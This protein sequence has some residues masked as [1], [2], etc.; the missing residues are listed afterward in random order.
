MEKVYCNL[1]FGFIRRSFGPEVADGFVVAEEAQAPFEQELAKNWVEWRT[2]INVMAL[3]AMAA[4]WPYR[5][6]Y[7]LLPENPSENPFGD[8]DAIH[9]PPLAQHS[10]HPSIV[11]FMELQRC[12]QTGKRKM[13][14]SLK[15]WA[16]VNGIVTL[17][18]VVNRDQHNG[19]LNY[20]EQQHEAYTSFVKLLG[21]HA[22]YLK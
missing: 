14:P 5:P 17:A 18:A 2:I 13:F 16:L 15:S 19:I 8:E 4:V 6:L 22:V 3:E 20:R 12:F 1:V 7:A 11:A 9:Y 10:E 21:D